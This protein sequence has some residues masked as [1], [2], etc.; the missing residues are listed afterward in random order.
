[1]R[2]HGYVSL[3][4]IATWLESLSANEIDTWEHLDE[5]FR[6]RYTTPS[7]MMK[8]KSAKDVTDIASSCKTT[9]VIIALLVAICR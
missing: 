1:M 3:L 5:V 4:I 7:Y 2:R 6:T 9:V 8:F